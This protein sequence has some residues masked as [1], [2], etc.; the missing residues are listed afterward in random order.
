MYKLLISY[1]PVSFYQG[2]GKADGYKRKCLENLFFISV[3]ST[4]PSPAVSQDVQ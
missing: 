2:G 4:G 1:V 3:Y